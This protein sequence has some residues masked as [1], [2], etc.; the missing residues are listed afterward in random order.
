MIRSLVASLV[1]VAAF[2]PAGAAFA[3]PDD[4]TKPAVVLRSADRTGNRVSTVPAPV[5]PPAADP[6]VSSQMQAVLDL[7]NVQRTARGLVA[8]RFSSQLNDAALDH[9]RRQA[10]DGEVYHTD[11]DD[12]SNTGQRISRT[13]YV[14][15]TWGE[16]VAAGY[17]TAQSVMKGWMSSP[18]HCR[19]ILNPAFTE[20]GIALVTGGVTYDQFWTQNFARP[21]DEPRP[22]GNYDSAWC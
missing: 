22:A 11:P 21:A 19:N 13:G 12:G 17:P 8:L 5:A 16:N 2:V 10:A 18:G 14:S 7:V 1:L 15:S 3:E 4:I 9:T 20:I 6:G